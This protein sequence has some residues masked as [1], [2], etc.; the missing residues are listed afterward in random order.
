MVAGDLRAISQVVRIDPDAVTTNQP[1]MIIQEIPLGCSGGKHIARIDS[2]FLKN[3]REFI[4]EGDVEIALG[5]FDD[6][7][8]F[9]DFD[10][11]RAMDAGGDNRPIHVGYDVEGARVLPRYDFLDSLEA[12]R[13]VARIDAFG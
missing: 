9:G 10:R 8:G 2:K 5:V 12:M 7:C 11:G 4:H 3:G 6:L 1:G 13:L